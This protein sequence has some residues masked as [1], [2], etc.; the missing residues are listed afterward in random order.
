MRIVLGKKKSLP[1]LWKTYAFRWQ[2]LYLLRH[3]PTSLCRRKEQRR[4]CGNTADQ[5][6]R[7][8]DCLAFV[9]QSSKSGSSPRHCL[10]RLQLPDSSR[11]S[12]IGVTPRV[13]RLETSDEGLSIYDF[14]FGTTY[15]AIKY[16][17]DTALY[18]AVGPI[19]G[20]IGVIVGLVAISLVIVFA[21]R[22]IILFWT[23]KKGG[24]TQ[25]AVT[26]Y[27]VYLSTAILFMLSTA[28]GL[29]AGRTSLS[30]VL[31]GAT[32]AGIVL[33]AVFMV[34][35]IVFDGINNRGVEL[36]RSYLVHGISAGVLCLLGVLVLSFD[37]FGLT[38][39]SMDAE[40]VTTGISYGI[41]TYSNLMYE[42]ANTLFSADTAIWREFLSNFVPSLVFMIL[43]F[44]LSI[45][46]IVSFILSMKGMLS[47][48]GCDFSRHAFTFG[49]V[50]GI[51]AV[52]LGIVKIVFPLCLASYFFPT[53]E[54]RLA[55]P[56]MIAV[57][58]S[59]I[60]AVTLAAKKMAKGIVRLPTKT[61]E[62]ESEER[63]ISK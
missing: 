63:T 21:I 29:S 22:A 23:K 38:A 6:G 62:K 9:L 15:D 35:A 57:F 17:G 59:L 24:M 32:I 39:V 47:R 51:S 37:G 49:I 16:G 33:G 34:A 55:S 36:P 40:G 31:N 11:L 43:T 13:S 50:A 45:A 41:L 52:L 20:T 27:L 3:S 25:Y 56:I 48:F 18:G 7:E 46:F 44:V 61:R 54:V 4:D 42:L 58:G 19:L 10:F 2:I 14:F 30:Y 60:L 1:S 5:T 28:N 8:A 26:A 53:F 12:L